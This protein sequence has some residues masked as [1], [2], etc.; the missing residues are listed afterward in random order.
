MSSPGG[1]GWFSFACAKPRT[2]RSTLLEANLAAKSETVPLCVPCE[3]GESGLRRVSTNGSLLSE[4]STAPGMR[5]GAEGHSR[6]ASF[7]DQQQQPLE[8]MCATVPKVIFTLAP[9]SH[10]LTLPLPPARRFYVP[11]RVDLSAMI[12]EEDEDDDSDDVATILEKLRRS[13][14][15]EDLCD[16]YEEAKLLVWMR[17]QQE[18]ARKTWGIKGSAAAI[19]E[20]RRGQLL[21]WGQAERACDGAKK[22]VEG[23]GQQAP[24]GSHD[25][26]GTSTEGSSSGAPGSPAQRRRTLLAAAMQSRK[27]GEFAHA[28]PDDGAIAR[29]LDGLRDVLK[30]RGLSEEMPLGE[31]ARAS[32]AGAPPLHGT[33][34]LWATATAAAAAAAAAITSPSSSASSTSSSPAVPPSSPSPPSPPL[35][36]SRQAALPPALA[37]EEPLPPAARQLWGVALG[38]TEPGSSTEPGSPA[39]ERGEDQ[40]D[41]LVD[42]LD[43]RVGDAFSQ[44][45]SLFR[46]ASP[47]ARPP[48]RS[49]PGSPP[50]S[51]PRIRQRDLPAVS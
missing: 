47:P 40:V 9:G 27:D 6:R 32:S 25:A 4:A 30:P 24:S 11:S 36:S 14:E 2:Q 10:L 43:S 37:S 41:V 12:D 23:N 19:A 50:G 38:G 33:D 35:P 26:A 46:S 44:F 28:P 15:Q 17:L 51:P 16:S 39:C 34:G 5:D 49:P 42:A 48:A 22:P 29:F 45:V 7:A 20:Y 21:R 1:T 8:K 13:D 31:D 3:T 18:A